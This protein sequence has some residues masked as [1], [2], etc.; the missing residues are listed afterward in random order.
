MGALHHVQSNRAFFFAT[1]ERVDEVGYAFGIGG[2]VNIPGLPGASYLAGQAVFA[3]GA[4]K[5][6][7][8][9]SRMS[10]YRAGGLNGGVLTDSW[11]VAGTLNLG[12][13][14]HVAVQGSASF[15]RHDDGIT[16]IDVWTAMG[17]VTFSPVQGL[18]FRAGVEYREEKFGAPF[19]A[20]DAG[21]L[22]GFFRVARTF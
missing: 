2:K 8:P 20:L 15:G 13:S 16:E 21:E 6:V 5:Y 14:E 19:G 17:D 11:G 4:T 12:V 18:A 1:G 10:D 7:D 3:H 9:S 22:I